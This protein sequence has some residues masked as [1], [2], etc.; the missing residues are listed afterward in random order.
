MP[1]GSISSSP[2]TVVSQITQPALSTALANL[3][4]QQAAELNSTWL[5]SSPGLPAPGRHIPDTSMCACRVWLWSTML[6][7]FARPRRTSMTT[8]GTGPS[9]TCC[10][11]CS[12][13]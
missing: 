13:F 10:F 9:C 7:P 11:L 2:D 6:C 3:L 4:L 12:A 1:V 5:F 8:A